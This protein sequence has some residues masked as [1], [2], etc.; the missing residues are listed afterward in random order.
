MKAL[1]T[2]LAAFASTLC[3]TAAAQNGEYEFTVVK[4]N[5]IT[6]IKNQ[7]RSGTCWCFSG[8]SFLE[9]EAIRIN[10]IKDKDA[11]PDFSEMFIVSHSY[12]TRA[13]KYVRLDGNL[14]FGPGSECEDVLHI[15]KDYGLVPQSVMPGLNYGT[16]LPVH[17]E[18]DAV[19]KAYVEAVNTLPNSTLSTAWLRGFTGILDAYFGECPV[20]FEYQGK[21]YT[22]RSYADSYNLNA[23]DYVSLTSFTHH[24]FYTKFP[25]EIADNWRYDQAYNLPL[26][27]LMDVLFG[28]I[29]KGYTTTW[30]GDV[31]EPGFT[32]NG[33]AVIPDTDAPASTSGSDQERWVG[34]DNS[35][36]EAKAEN[37][38]PRE[39]A[40][41]QEYRQ[42]GFDEKTTT[43]DHGMQAFG[44]AKDQNGTRYLM[45]KNSWG[46]T[47][48]YKGIWYI[49]ESFTR[50]KMIDF[51]VHKDALPK[52][53]KAKLGIK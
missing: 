8:L 9:S 52:E 21:S 12:Q 43:D 45:I 31:S 32:R 24:P 1:H 36:P 23:D 48:K 6:S 27:E 3:I 2:I 39:K 37:S 11:Y 42:K 15:M 28:A 10:K 5:P 35:Q 16:E 47:G 4:E 26:D 13:D 19:L 18:L 46:E 40:I 30:G 33:I 41:S 34:K 50:A 49:S 29:E 17:G 51:M 25:I 53:L 44:I 38:V 20:K 7:N 22:P 14:T